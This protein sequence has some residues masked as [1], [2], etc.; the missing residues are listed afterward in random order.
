[1][2]RLATKMPDKVFE[3][4]QT[5]AGVILSEFRTSGESPWAVDVTKIIGA[6]SGGV[7][8]TDTPSYTDYGED[9]DNCPKNTMEL[10][11]IDYREV[12][13]SGTYVSVTP[14]Q[15]KSLAASADLDAGGLEIK[16]RSELKVEDFEDIWFVC[17]YGTNNAIAIHIKNALSTGGFALQTTDRAKGTFAFEYTGHYSLETPEDVPYEVF[18]KQ[19][20]TVG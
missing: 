20:D 7:S 19:A 3:H 13:L 14:A 10:K 18:F 17:D 15:V 16:P 8:F 11:R 6:T 12:K 2:A 1:M 9:I 4:I 5:N